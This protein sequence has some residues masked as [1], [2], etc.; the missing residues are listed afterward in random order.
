MKYKIDHK[1]IYKYVAPVVQSHHILH[2]SPRDVSH[3][4]ISG[5]SLIIDPAPASRKDFIDYNGNP[6]SLVT[7]EQEH[8]SLQFYSHSEIDLAVNNIDVSAQTTGWEEAVLEA[9]LSGALDILQYS[10]ISRHTQPDEDIQNYALK[11]FTAGRPVLEGALE[12]TQRIFSEFTFDNTATDVST[13]ISEVMKMKRGV[14]QDFAHLQAA[15]LRVLGIPS[16][17]VSGYILTHPPEGMKKL[18]GT[19]ASHAWVS[20]WCGKEFGWVDFDPTNNMIPYDEHITFAY[21]MDFDDVSPVSGVLI[22]GGDHTVSV[23][24]DVIPVE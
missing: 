2:L 23:A 18:A 22:G 1:T 8:S 6:V 5:H 21:G 17:Y 19:D 13:P 3:Q 14:C 11:S 10:C 24:V 7:I 16:R 15:C 12:L 4:V 20:A 9:R